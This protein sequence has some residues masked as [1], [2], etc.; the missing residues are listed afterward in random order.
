MHHDAPGIRKECIYLAGMYRLNKTL[1]DLIDQLE[2]EKDSKIRGLIAFALYK[3]GEEKGIQ[4][5]Y[6]A[7]L[8]ETDPF[9]NHMLKSVVYQYSMDR[10]QKL[11]MK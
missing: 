9:A 1:D 8:K 2:V 6:K 7:Y 3:I 4:A 11:T 10:N 5:A